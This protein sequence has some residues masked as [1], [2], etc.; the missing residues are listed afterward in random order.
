MFPLTLAQPIVGVT[1]LLKAAKSPWPDLPPGAST[2]DCDYSWHSRL[3]VAKG[4]AA[5]SEQAQTC[6]DHLGVEQGAS[7]LRDHVQA[8]SEPFGG[9]VGP[10]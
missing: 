5:L 3:A 1:A 7:S 8:S 9:R 4:E 2:T 10:V 6:I